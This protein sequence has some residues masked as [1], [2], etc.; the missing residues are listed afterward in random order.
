MSRRSN[1]DAPE[2]SKTKKQKTAKDQDVI[3][4]SDSEGE[5]LTESRLGIIQ[6]V[7]LQDFMCHSHLEVEFGSRLNFINGENGSNAILTAITIAL[8]GKASFTNRSTNMQG[9]IKESKQ[10]AIVKV[11]LYNEGPD[12]FKPQ[13]YANLIQIE[14]AIF[15][16]SKSNSYK[17]KNGITGHIISTKK[18][19]LTA[20]VD[21]LAI[22]I[23]N[24]INILSQDASREFL[25]SS[26]PDQLYQWFLKGTQLQQLSDDLEAV[27]ETVGIVENYITKRQS[28][29]PEMKSRKLEWEQKYQ[30]LTQA[31]QLIQ[32]MQSMEE[33]LAWSFVS[34]AEKSRDK[35][36]ALI[37]EQLGKVE[38]IAAKIDLEKKKIDAIE[39]FVMEKQKELA[40]IAGRI[41]PIQVKKS[42]ASTAESALVAELRRLKNNE[43][44]MNA[45]AREYRK[46]LEALKNQIKNEKRRL[47][48]DQK[49][50]K[51]KVENLKALLNTEN[52]EIKNKISSGKL[53]LQSIDSELTIFQQNSA[54]ISDKID[55]IKANIMNK[56][57][58]I[59]RL[60]QQS[61]NSL[62]AFGR[63][64]SEVASEIPKNKWVGRSPIGPLGKYVKLKD[65]KWN[66]VIETIL[67]K[68]L[69]MFM[70]D[71]HQDRTTLDNIMRRCNCQ[72]GILI[73]KPELFDYKAGEPDSSYKT[74]LRS[75]EIEDEIVKRQLI[76]INRIEQILLVE[77]RS[78][79]D[80]IMKSNNG[81]FPKNVVACFT[82]DGFQV[83]S[84]TGGFSTLAANLVKP[85]GRLTEDLSSIISRFN[86]SVEQSNNELEKT[87]SEKFE[88]K[89]KIAHAVQE[90]KNIDEQRRNGIRRMDAINEQLNKIDLE[91]AE[92]EPANIMA[93]EAEQRDVQESLLMVQR[94]F[95]DQ[96]EAKESLNERLKNSKTKELEVEISTLTKQA[97]VVCAERPGIDNNLTS[98]QLQADIEALS[99][100]IS[101]IES[102][103]SQS[104][105]EIT[106]Q[107]Q[108]YISDYNTA[109]KQLRRMI[110]YVKTLK[111]AYQLRLK[112]WI[113]F[114]D[115]MTVRIKSQFTLHL[116][117]RG[118]AGSLEFDHTGQL[119]TPR[120]HT[121]ND[122]AL[123]AA[124][125]TSDLSDF[126]KKKSTSL[127]EKSEN[128]NVEINNVNKSYD[129]NNSQ[130]KNLQ[131]NIF[132]YRKDTKS[133]SG[134]EKSFTTI[135]F[136]LSLWEA[137]SCP[138]R[139]LDEF[140]VFMDA[141]NRAISMRMIVKSARCSPDTQFLLISP[142]DMTIKPAA[143]IKIL[144]LYAPN[145][146]S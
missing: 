94:Q 82:V 46:R 63:G 115:S 73:C 5:E 55:Q 87:N 109:K 137:M 35:N 119:L 11:W 118:Y 93:L 80:D 49:S 52:E 142:Q 26:K 70:V 7:E 81:R 50:E 127:D 116:Y 79:A 10:R 37:L 38:K 78:L 100:T 61:K 128:D 101:E 69:N 75:I 110:Y 20:I 53:K 58:D 21:H 134:G 114:R 133:L 43:L 29:M 4:D 60:K 90:S 12:A 76:N 99:K 31:R 57:R 88:L 19:E 102:S 98:A 135:S 122:L 67:D 111:E 27:R 41:D 131:Q 86:N 126:V 47:E 51:A 30:M 83:G 89:K 141:A 136:L 32:N 85:T 139:A 56:K 25:A 112:R 64:V 48:G 132:N 107:A 108:K 138:I 65:I 13:E 45:D 17:L 28:I 42:D 95:A 121:D 113:I 105:E 91:I 77:F 54:K 8:G 9:F 71:N 96:L 14:R 6:K 124:N 84:R 16:D 24:P 72:S 130:S 106:I 140:D 104:I 146:T 62:L 74:V 129:Q 117:R 120:V 143:D 97:E 18:S 23:E 68:S 144:F 34:D 1:V 123:I 145:R 36:N 33:K 15:R 66:T 22:Q 92:Q 59:E 103:Q 44:E 39:S 2:N 40:D 125:N 3:N